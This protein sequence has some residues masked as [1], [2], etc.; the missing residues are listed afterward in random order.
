MLAEEKANHL[1]AVAEQAA[2]RRQN[3][4]NNFSSSCNKSTSIARARIPTRKRPPNSRAVWP[5]WNWNSNRPA[6]TSNA[7]RSAGKSTRRRPSFYPTN[8]RNVTGNCMRFKTSFRTFTRSGKFGSERDCS[9][10]ARLESVTAVAAN[11]IIAETPVAEEP[12]AEEPIGKS[13]SRKSQLPKSQL[14]KTQLPKKRSP[15]F[16]NCR[17]TT[18]REDGTDL[19]P[20][21]EKG[22]TG[23]T[24]MPLRRTNSAWV[25]LRTDEESFD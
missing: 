5:I 4:K 21:D 2:R 22:P 23:R 17:S 20:I 1:S 16:R 8:W 11:S 25:S 7:Y 19:S 6:M 14:L 13:Q 18:L 10:E 12:V 15:T 24:P 3:F 9:L